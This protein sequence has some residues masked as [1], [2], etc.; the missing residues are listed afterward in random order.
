MHAA[1]T[2]VSDLVHFFSHCIG[3]TSNGCLTAGNRISPH[4]VDTNQ[5]GSPLPY[6]L[7]VQPFEASPSAASEAHGVWRRK[8][9]AAPLKS[10]SRRLAPG[11]FTAHVEELS[12]P[13]L[14]PQPRTYGCSPMHKHV[15][16]CKLKPKEKPFIWARA[17]ACDRICMSVWVQICEHP[18]TISTPAPFE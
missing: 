4:G 11:D 17:C 2:Q 9:A 8:V 3:G 5:S 7:A 6:H 15:R 10:A 13:F 12:A 16:P 18:R 14:I 1:A